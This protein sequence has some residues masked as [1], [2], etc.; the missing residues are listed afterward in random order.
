MPAFLLFQ[1][2]PLQDKK[3]VPAEENKL[4]GRPFRKHGL[5]G[6]FS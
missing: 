3:Y 6:S 5:K 4:A 1:M 2:A